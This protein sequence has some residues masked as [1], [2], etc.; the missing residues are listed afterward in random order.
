MYRT[1]PMQD[2]HGLLFDASAFAVTKS[3]RDD[4]GQMFI[5]GLASI[6]AI[7]QTGGRTSP[8]ALAKMPVGL[9]GIPL[10]EEYL[11]G[12][13]GKL[14][15]IVK[16]DSVRDE[17][18]TWSGLFPAQR[19]ANPALLPAGQSEAVKKQLLQLDPAEKLG[20]VD[21]ECV[22]PIQQQL[23]P[24]FQTGERQDLR[25]Q[26][27]PAMRAALLLESQMQTAEVD[28]IVGD[29]HPP[30]A[31]GTGKLLGIIEACRSLL[32]CCEY[33]ESA[34]AQRRCQTIVDTFI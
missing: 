3:Y 23:R 7:V 29:E 33:V 21:R 24:R 8:G 16:A 25:E 34:A 13:S 4:N 15:E 30:Q 1:D 10:G 11:R 22:N 27:H 19:Q 28:L 32:R 17:E 5:E 9:T 2:Q 18:R 31:R 26:D 20:F 6:N 12:Y 14:S